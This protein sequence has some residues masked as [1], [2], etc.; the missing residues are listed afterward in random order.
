MLMHYFL[1]FEFKFVFEFICLVVFQKD[2]TSFSFFLIP[3]PFLAGFSL[4]P[5]L[6][7]S[8]SRP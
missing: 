7:K 5:N 3:L 8:G 1:V 2:K 4:K 6:Q